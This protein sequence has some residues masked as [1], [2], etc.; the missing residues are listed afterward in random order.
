MLQNYTGFHWAK[1]VFFFE[2][3]PHV[4]QYHLFNVIVFPQRGFNMDFN[5]EKVKVDKL[6]KDKDWPNGK[7]LIRMVLQSSD[8]ICF[9][10]G[11]KV[12][13]TEVQY[14]KHYWKGKSRFYK[15]SKNLNALS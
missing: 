8:L 12:E 11:I 6:E 5:N 14:W 9:I 1:L 4:S 15:M 13:P 3:E 7:F 2:K 10:N